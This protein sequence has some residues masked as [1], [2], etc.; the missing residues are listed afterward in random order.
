MEYYAAIKKNE[1]MLSAATCMDLAIN[2][3]K[4]SQSEKDMSYIR[5]MWNQKLTQM[6]L[7]TEQNRLTD[8]E[9][10]RERWEG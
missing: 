6:N 10:P 7:F 9:N 3:A 5:Y 8:L 2:Y 4:W 1:I